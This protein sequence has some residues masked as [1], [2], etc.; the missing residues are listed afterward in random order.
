MGK[1][2]CIFLLIGLMLTPL[3]FAQQKERMEGKASYYGT[4]FHGKKTANGEIFN[5]NN[6]TAAHRKLPFN[7]LVKVTN[8]R[9]NNSVIVRINDR[10]P[11]SK[12]RVIDVS[13]A[14]AEKLGMVER[15][16][17]NVTIEVLEPY[18]I[19]NISTEY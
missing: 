16:T 14:A 4:R 2:I 5:M 18:N 6:L 9:N 3:V 19:Q 12:N 13:K 15:G 7:T 10:G 8:K 17:A 1:F 11:Y